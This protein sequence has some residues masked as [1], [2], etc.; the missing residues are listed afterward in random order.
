[1]TR[2]EMQKQI[3]S[4]MPTPQQIVESIDKKMEADDTQVGKALMYVADK[5]YKLG[6]RDAV[7]EAYKWLK[8]RVEHDSIDYPMASEHLIDEFKEYIEK[9]L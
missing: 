6:Y 1:M 9:R 2:E 3:E 5:C 4:M 8:D 7:D